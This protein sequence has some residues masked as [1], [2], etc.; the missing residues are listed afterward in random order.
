MPDAVT[1]PG[2][3]G[4]TGEEVDVVVVGAGFAGLYALYRLRELGLRARVFEAGDDV[5]GTWYWNRYVG[6]RCDTNSL[7]YCYSFSDELRAEWRWAERYPARSELLAYL[8]HVA[9]RFD[10]RKDIR[11]ATR[12]TR[13]EYDEPANRW[14]VTTHAGERIRARFVVTAVGCLSDVQ[15]P[16]FPG[17]D[18]FAGEWFH[19]ARWP[20]PPADFRGQRVGVIGTGSSG[21]QVIPEI[22]REALHLTVFQRTPNYVLPAR[23]A[24]LDP[25][26]IRQAYADPSSLRQ[27]I[28]RSSAGIPI[29]HPTR[30]AMDLSPEDRERVYQE[31]WDR[32][33]VAEFLFAFSDLRSDTAAN[34]TASDF[35]RSKIREIVRDPVTAE[36]LCPK[37]PLGAKRT[38][39]GTDYY[40]TFNRDNVE[41]VDVSQTPIRAIDRDGV[42]VGE[43]HQ[44]LTQLVFATGFDAMTGALLEIDIRGRCGQTLRERWGNGPRTYLGLATSGFPNLFMLTGPGSPS[45][46][47]NVVV[48]IEQHVEWVTDLLRYAQR[49][50]VELAEARRDAEDGWVEHVNELGRRSIISTGNSWYLGANI[51]GKPR[52]FLPYAGGYDRYRAI[53]DA[54]ARKGYEGFDLAPR[55]TVGPGRP[56][57]AG[58]PAAA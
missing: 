38:Q 14:S 18:S 56:G 51:P 22:A 8:R 2:R 10:L 44:P 58:D 1:E 43:R 31:R 28:R 34:Q 3:P 23:N 47:G 27:R 50:G 45:V 30:A 46:L 55:R 36:L 35:I 17:L 4:V 52:V 25:E 13:A 5:G 20:D 6:A 7:F 26:A 41:L 9:D 39:L 37:L 48:A 21:V 15:V 40:E 12:I 53:C 54:V 57:P 32:G 19:T 33:G 24:P 42:W 16:A 29:E 49:A 11:F